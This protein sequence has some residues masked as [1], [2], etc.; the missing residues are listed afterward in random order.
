MTSTPSAS[1]DGPLSQAQQR[2]WFLDQ[3]E[4]DPS[5]HQLAWLFRLH[6]PLDVEKFRAALNAVVARHDILRTTFPEVDG[7]P[8]A[9]VHASGPVE[10]PLFESATAPVPSPH[11]DL[12]NGPLFSARLT[13]VSENEHHF[14]WTAHRIVFDTHSLWAFLRD[15]V[16]PWRGE[17]LPGEARFGEFTQAESAFLESAE[18]AARLAFWKEYLAP[19]LPTLQYPLDRPRPAVQTFASDTRSISIKTRD[20]APLAML[21]KLKPGGPPCQSAIFLAVY[22]V[23]LHRHTHQNDLTIGRPLRNL[24]DAT[25]DP[26]LG[27]KALLKIFRTDFVAD[28]TFLSFFERVLQNIRTAQAERDVPFESILEMVQ[29]ERNL[30]YHPLVQTTFEFD[31]NRAPLAFDLST[32]CTDTL[33]T[34]E[35]ERL[36]SGT[37][38]DLSMFAETAFDQVHFTLQFNRD[39]FPAATV[40]RLLQHYRQLLISIVKNPESSIA[41]LPMLTAEERQQ[42]LVDWNTTDVDHRCG[43]FLH[44]RFEQQVAK[45][46]NEAAV[47][48]GEQSVT[49]DELNRRA[50]QLA[51]HL[52]TAGVGPEMRVGVSMH[53][54]FEMLVAILG[55][56]KAGAGYVPL[57]P[58]VPAERLHYMIE[59]AQLA[60][61]LT[62]QRFVE[63]L[64]PHGVAL[65]PIDT[66]WAKIDTEL[67]TNLEAPAFADSLVYITYTSGS[68]GKPKGILM[69]QRPLLNLLGWMLRTTDLPPRA[70]TL[71]FASLSFDVSFQDIF[72]TWLS[73]GTLVLISEAQRQDLAGLAG[74]LDQYQVH[75]LFLPAVALQQLAEG[76]CNGNYACTNL[77]KIISGSEQ[78]MVTDALRKM[79]TVLPQCRL[80][81]EYGPSEAHVVTELKMPD[82]PATWVVRP[83]VGKPIDNTQMYI[84]DRVGQ[85]VPVGVIGELHIG[86][87]CLARGY[88]GRAELT[89]EKF[90]PNPFSK[91]PGARM[92]RT[93]DQARW[94]ANGDIEFVGRVDH[95]IKIRGYRVEPSDVEAALEKHEQVREAFVMAREFGPGDKRLVAYLGLDLAKAPGVSELRGFLATKLPEYMIPSAFVLLEKLPLNANG[96]V[97]RKALPAPDS[98]R[99]ELATAYVAPQGGLEE[100]L[101]VQWCDLLKLNRVGS[102]DNFFDLGGN[103]VMIVQI[104]HRLKQHLQRDLPLIALFQY[105]TIDTLAQFLGA[106][107]TRGP[108]QQQSIVDRAARQ[109]AAQAQRRP[110]AT[111]S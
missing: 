22:A 50:N 5:A 25:G 105:P 64:T 41:N 20:L 98:A 58:A 35:V 39:L 97:D 32:P 37:P 110:L 83:A 43:E 3:F 1:A 106:E 74:L 85:I 38:Y 78:I 7:Q 17:P 18:A 34:T 28:E 4:R 66:D 100:F 104:H 77:R 72:S 96:K 47:I 30:S 27:P 10:C 81:N 109:R 56:L 90:V 61:I 29:P 8:V 51:H 93:G 55:V 63:T 94:L 99:P 23:L 52:R 54:S 108:A 71:Q 6:G 14:R 79:F 46:P 111:H 75:R 70:R 88:L 86:G 16:R 24:R 76:F 11:F 53:R 84:L 67:G 92:Y 42:L 31:P 36:P 2:L 12:T 91:E 103:S 15:L 82:D 102:R 40:E 73:G 60:L 44:E 26:A 68:T 69:T 21:P 33:L 80:H 95:Q 101:A 107:D 89:A 49:Y 19:P 65:L 59:D 45:T 48:F 57:D 62:Q 87:V 13:R 9:R